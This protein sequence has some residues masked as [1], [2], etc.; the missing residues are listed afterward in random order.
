MADYVGRVLAAAPSH[1]QLRT[2][3][4]VTAWEEWLPP[5]RIEAAPESFRALVAVASIQPP[6]GESMMQ[7]AASFDPAYLESLIWA[8][9][10]KTAGITTAG[11]RRFL[12]KSL[13]RRAGRGS[14]G[15]GPT[16]R[17]CGAFF[18]A[19]I[20]VTPERYGAVPRFDLFGS[21]DR[22][23][24]PETQARIAR[25]SAPGR[26]RTI[27]ADHMPFFS[28]PA[29][30]AVVHGSDREELLAATPF[31][32]CAARRTN[33]KLNG[34]VCAAVHSSKGIA[35]QI[36]ARELGSPACAA[37]HAT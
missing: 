10:G 3:L 28:N 30:L 7:V 18:S 34:H 14:R 1:S 2:F 17:T 27:D 25:N 15:T 23:I 13:L 6:P 35:D 16:A 19:P 20:L 24:S 21:G 29:A 8:E 4:P 36:P 32:G 37:P 31:G 11:V 12:C 9:D 26:L 33:L 5:K 22:L